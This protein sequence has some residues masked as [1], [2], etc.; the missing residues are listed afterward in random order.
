MS[1]QIYYKATGIKEKVVQEIIALAKK[2][3]VE[4]VILFG[5]REEVILKS[6]VMWI[7]RFAEERAAVLCWMSMRRPPLCWNLISLI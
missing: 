7:W 1:E 3:Q 2:Y 5:S 6:A 4:K